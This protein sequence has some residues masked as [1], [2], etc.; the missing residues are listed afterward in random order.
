M[1][2]FKMKRAKLVVEKVRKILKLFIKVVSLFRYL[3]GIG[4][5]C[6]NHYVPLKKQYRF[7]ASE[8]RRATKEGEFI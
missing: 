6:N 2:V 7:R 1:N 5:L 4:Q 8:A 3:Y